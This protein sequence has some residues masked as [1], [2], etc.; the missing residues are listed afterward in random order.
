MSDLNFFMPIAK[1]DDAQRMVWG[2]ASTP[3]LDLDNEIVTIDAI[4]AALPDYMEWANIREMH[5]PSAVGVAKEANIDTKGLYLGARI[6]DEEAWQ[7][8]LDGVYKGFSIGGKILEKVGKEIRALSLIE[9]SL[10]DRPANPDARID[11]FK[12]AEFI[13]GPLTLMKSAMVRD[14]V[15]P[16]LSDDLVFKAEDRPALSRLVKW[17]GLAKGGNE[18][19]DGS[20][21]YGDVEYADPGHQADGKHR[22]PIDTE[23]HIRAAWSYI[24]KPKN[25]EG[26][27]PSQLASIK[28]KIEAAWKE[29][30]DPKGPPEAGKAAKA[31][32]TT[33][34]DKSM[35]VVADLAYAFGSIRSAQRSLIRE[36]MIEGDGDDKEFADEL[37]RIAQQLAVVMGRK[38][39]HEGT[40]ALMLDDADDI[41]SDE[42]N[43]YGYGVPIMAGAT[44][45]AAEKAIL[46]KRRG[47][48]T[49]GEHLAKAKEHIAKCMSFHKEAMSE[50]A[51]AAKMHHDFAHSLKAAADG[52][53][54]PEF[55]HPTAMKHM[56]AVAQ[57]LGDAHDH[58]ELADHHLGKAAGTGGEMQEEPNHDAPTDD[59]IQGGGGNLAPPHGHDYDAISPFPG[60]GARTG[61]TKEQVDLM[62][63]SA[64]NAAKAESLEK[65][66][67]SFSR[68]PGARLPVQV[69]SV[70]KTAAAGGNTNTRDLLLADVDTSAFATD[71][72]G[73]VIN[74]TAAQSSAANLMGNIL[75]NPQAFG[76]SLSDPGFR[77]SMGR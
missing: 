76:K 43:S 14:I 52:T 27:T 67:S 5:Q 75:R 44:L 33:D 8:V 63:E 3:T 16:E 56:A 48:S 54:K 59:G 60:K 32:D 23:N 50:C 25:Q 71:G 38:A 45:T 49:R 69:F 53:D 55:D 65:A 11:A 36:G 58:A 13:D 4:K 46:A 17:L 47:S 34:I 2:Y 1:K 72:E 66:L 30:I 61:Y 51:K 77:S 40:E 6:T 64:V 57:H 20:K 37:G 39:E 21:P 41:I 12:N 35:Y 62:V 28:A 18:P 42:F 29:K 24:H 7:K 10:V 31:V 19:G 68:A 9:I 26:Y 15:D 73:N 22:Y 70:D 74:K